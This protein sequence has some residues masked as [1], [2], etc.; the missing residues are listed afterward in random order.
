VAA[1]A[2]CR[3]YVASTAW[4]FAACALSLFAVEVR[5]VTGTLSG[6]HKDREGNM[7]R[8]LSYAVGLVL[9]AGCASPADEV[10]DSPDAATP[11]GTETASGAPRTGPVAPPTTNEEMIASAMAAAPAAVS[12]EATIIAVDENGQVRT[13]RQGS[14]PFTCIPDGPS[15]GVDPMCLDPNGL[16]W[17]KAWIAR[18]PP[19]D[20]I[21]GFGYMLA[22][23]SDASN[24]DPFASE[25]AAGSDWIETGPHVMI[26]TS[27]LSGYPTT[28]DDAS[29]PFLMWAGTPYV[30]L[31]A[32]VR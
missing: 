22:G 32:P 7:S 25:P 13:L 20:G 3:R 21:V 24:E 1:D 11:E 18:Q 31:M 27:G 26:F 12:G 29:R 28:H 17:V 14:G 30:H 15:P 16:A 2:R 8:W 5:K 10:A 23:G 9:L 6:I 4:L 19:P